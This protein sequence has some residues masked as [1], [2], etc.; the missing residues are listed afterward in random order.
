MQSKGNHQRIKAKM[1]GE[2][3]GALKVKPCRVV[4][5][6]KKKPCRV[7][8]LLAKYVW[9]IR[10]GKMTYYVF[11]RLTLT[12]KFTELIYLSLSGK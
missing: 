7:V 3:K 8:V 6:K 2:K 9:L 1:G 12:Q 11:H 5:Q 10:T 4:S